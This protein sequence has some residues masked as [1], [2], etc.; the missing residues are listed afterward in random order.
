MAATFKVAVSGGVIGFE[1][2]VNTPNGRPDRLRVYGP[3][4]TG[5]PMLTVQV[6]NEP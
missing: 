2:K 4:L 6:A 1:E 3:G 5:L